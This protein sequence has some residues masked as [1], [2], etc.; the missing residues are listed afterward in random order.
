LE[1]LRP[2]RRALL[3]Q[4][5]LLVVIV[6]STFGTEAGS[7]LSLRAVGEDSDEVRAFSGLPGSTI[8]LAGSNANRSRPSG[9]F[10]QSRHQF[11]VKQKKAFAAVSQPLSYRIDGG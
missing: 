2:A 8:L 4:I 6:P 10:N 9:R 5:P 1:P 11:N 7:V 3:D